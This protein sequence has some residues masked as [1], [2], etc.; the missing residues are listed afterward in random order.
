M[1]QA[2]LVLDVVTKLFGIR[3]GEPEPDLG[4]ASPQSLRRLGPGRSIR[5]FGK[6]LGPG[7][8]IRLFGKLRK[9]VIPGRLCALLIAGRYKAI[10]HIVCGSFLLIKG[11]KYDM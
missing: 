5:L 7:R 10:L 4:D 1:T 11:G 6:L 3:A 9:L 8:S 2:F